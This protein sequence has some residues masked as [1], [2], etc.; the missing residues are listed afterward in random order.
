LWIRQEDKDIL[1]DNK[2]IRERKEFFA[3]LSGIIFIFLIFAFIGK[4]GWGAESESKIGEVAQYCE[5][6]QEGWIREPANT[7]SNLAFIFVGLYIL[8]MI[9]YDPTDG[10]PSL[11]TRSWFLIMYAISCA[12]VGVGSLAMHGFNTDWGGWLD[13][14]GMMMYITMP[15]FYNF[16]RFF[17][18][19]ENQFCMYYLCT[20]VVLSILHWS[21][22]IGLLVWGFSIGIWLA[23][24][25]AIKYQNR[26]I[27]IFMVPIVLTI[28]LTAYNPIDFLKE[29][30]IPIIFWA[31]MAYFLHKMPEIKLERTYSPYFWAGFASYF[32]ATIIWRPS[33][34]DGWMCDPDTLLQG[35]AAWHFLGAIAMW[36][37]YNY[38]RTEKDSY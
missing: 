30:Y 35:H 23:Q 28:I 13:L 21:F 24:E 29:Q 6:I 3:V 8:W 27:A 12:A 33:Q 14:T 31:I 36:C 4:D 11:S 22:G 38:F 20:N 16:S 37:F 10:Y 1:I 18:W 26:P 9:Q 19:D 7:I 34:K 32:I 15:V 25:T 2:Y 5:R 17:R